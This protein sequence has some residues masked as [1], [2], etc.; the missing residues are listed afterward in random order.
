MPIPILTI[1]QMRQWEQATWAAGKNEWAVIEQVG[2]RLSRRLLQRT[3]P[4]ARILIVS[5]R[6]HNGED[7]RAITPHLKEREIRLVQINDP[8]R[9]LGSLER[10]L[11]WAPDWI[12]DGL[13]GIGLNRPLDEAWQTCIQRINASRASV[14]SV[15][16]PS[17]LNAA[18]GEVMGAAIQATL[19]V[20]VGAPK[21]G[22]LTPEAWRWTG[23]LDVEPDIG[24]IL[25]CPVSSDQ[26]WTLPEDFA[27]FPSPR[28]LNA[29]KG[30]FGHLVIVAGSVGYHGASVLAARGAQR[31]QPGL[32]SLWTMP[33]TYVPVA[34]QLQ[35]VMVHPWE[36]ETPNWPERTSAFLFGPGLAAVP[37]DHPMRRVFREI[38]D[39]APVPV[40]VDASALDWVP[41]GRFSSGALRVITP[42]PGEAARMLRTEVSKIQQDRPAA[43]RELSRRFGNCWVVLKGRFTLIG[44][45]EGPIFWNPTGNPYLAQGGA[46]DVLAGYLAGWLAQP[47]IAQKDAERA[48]RFAVWE[49]GAAADRLMISPRP[50]TPEDLIFE[51]GNR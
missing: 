15:D 44:R 49:H 21:V 40:I 28:P 39:T 2:E 36:G 14:L 26:Q 1:E 30:Y 13:F 23:V 25:P 45:A 31:A 33:E 42:H 20:T 7:A 29:H 32:I 27:G 46:G 4:G 18:T 5:G 19:T 37:E 47:E 43:V 16:V 48:I 22:L 50:W 12:V 11:A 51:L 17:G 24:L 10:G 41:E 38:W 3:R 34:A 35:A 6:G 8:S 9:D